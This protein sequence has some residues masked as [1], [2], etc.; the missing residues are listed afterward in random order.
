MSN[1]HR[2]VRVKIVLLGDGAVGKTSIAKRYLGHG[3][4]Q[5]YKATIG[6]DFYIKKTE[7]TLNDSKFL[8]E[9]SIW[10]LAGQPHWKEVRP[11]FYAGAQGALIVFDVTR[12]QTLLNV[13]E[14][15]NEF[16]KNS[17]HS[18][19]TI[20]EVVTGVPSKS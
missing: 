11:G 14:W 7:L 18:I 13:I 16:I 6:V 15:T 19:K 17:G 2:L 12:K 8:I 4:I 10:D 5:E 3:F 1:E 20:N 9:W